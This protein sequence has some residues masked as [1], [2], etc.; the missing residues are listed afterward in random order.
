MRLSAV[1]CAALMHAACATTPAS[2][3]AAGYLVPG[4][5][6][7]DRGPDGNGIFLDAP[8]GLILDTLVTVR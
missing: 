3:P 2:S 1:L 4:T 6:E 5:F 8:A 7:P